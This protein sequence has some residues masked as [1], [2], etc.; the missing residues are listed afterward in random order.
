MEK[1]LDIIGWSALIKSTLSNL[2]TYYLSM[3]KAPTKVVKI[4]EKMQRDFLWVPGDSKNDHLIKWEIVCRLI[5]KGGGLGLGNLGIR[6][7]ALLTK[8]LWGFPHEEGSLWHS[9][10]FA[11]Y[12]L[13][14]NSWDANMDGR[15]L[16]SCP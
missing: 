14:V 10:I 11:K 5:A 4:I 6:N 2:P 9:G 15:V 12:G 7:D 13:H 16:V 8:W 3:L 1:K